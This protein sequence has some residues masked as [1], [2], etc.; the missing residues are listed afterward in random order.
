MRVSFVFLFGL[1]V[2]LISAQNRYQQ[3]IETEYRG[4]TVVLISTKKP[5][6]GIVYLENKDDAFLS[7]DQYVDGLRNGYSISTKNGVRISENNFKNGQ[8]NG[9][10]RTWNENG[11]LAVETN[12]VDGVSNGKFN[13]F[14][15]NG[16]LKIEGV[17]SMGKL[18][19][20]YMEYYES[21]NMKK[22]EFWK[23]GLLEGFCITYLENATNGMIKSKISYKAGEIHGKC[24]WFNEKGIILCEAQYENGKQNGLTTMWHDNGQKLHRGNYKDG[25]IDGICKSWYPNGKKSIQLKLKSDK[26]IYEKFWD[27]NGNAI[28]HDG[29]LFPPP[30]H[31]I[32]QD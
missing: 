20:K 19:G 27:E 18:N 6:T 5:V 10:S 9:V 7:E 32:Y 8:L 3:I 2:N 4:D 22:V 24:K 30:P 14:Y 28:K 13:Y 26:M 25:R 29:P 31:S 1:L 21:G 16:N 15:E 11:K 23:N 17:N 12:W